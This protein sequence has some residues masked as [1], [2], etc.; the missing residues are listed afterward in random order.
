VGLSNYP[1]DRAKEA[2]QIIQKFGVKLLIH[3][4]KFS[5]LNRWIQ[6]DGLVEAM[7]DEEMGIIPFSILSQGLLT[8]KYIKGVPRDSRAGNPN[9]PFLTE[10]NVTAEL[11]IKLQQLKEI[12]QWLKWLWLGLL[13]KKELQVL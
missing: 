7:A 13:P 3:Q 10:N 11:I 5:M 4:P 9:V 12:K 1:V 8:E 6:D 2:S